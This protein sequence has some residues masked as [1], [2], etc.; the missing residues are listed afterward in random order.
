M[1]VGRSSSTLK[2]L[3]AAQAAYDRAVAALAS[4]KA[5]VKVAEAD[6]SSNETE[7]GKAV[8][9]S[10][11]SGIVLSRNVDPGQTVAA[12]L[13]A[14]VL[15]TI[16]EDL[17]KMNL[18]VDIDEADAGSVKEGQEAVFT[19]EAYPDR[20]FAA[21]VLQLR[22]A[23]E[24]VNGVVTYKAVLSVDNADLSLRPGMTATAEIIT[25]KAT[26]ALLVPNGALRYAPP[27]TAVA[28]NRPFLQRLMPRPPSR[29]PKV[30]K[31]PA[32]E[33]RI[34]ILQDGVPA[35]VSIAVGASDGTATEVLKGELAEGALLV[36]DA[37]TAK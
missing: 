12:T 4:A 36:T 23:P 37:V 18:L 1:L 17:A 22:F 30:E 15:F 9:R 27:E 35:A 20:K 5:Q 13:Q 26:N 10:P 34:Y 7:L 11:I 25:R 32:G 28:D 8:I 31:L 24:T 2:D 14:P 19:V 3:Q 33:R 16:A 21:R 29:P 6:L